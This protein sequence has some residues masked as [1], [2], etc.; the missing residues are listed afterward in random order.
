MCSETRPTSSG[1]PEVQQTAP[2][3]VSGL[4]RAF[5]V[6]PDVD[7]APQANPDVDLAPP[8]LHHALLDIDYSSLGLHHAP[9]VNP[10]NPDL[11]H[12]PPDHYAHQVNPDL[13]HPQVNPDLDHAPPRL[14]HASPRLDH[15]LE[16]GSELI[17]AQQRARDSAAIW[18]SWL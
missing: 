16:T 11:D 9:Q 7:R 6:N 18:G 5:Q 3:Q 8:G 10:V 4:N 1:D 17:P 15:A 13:D 14:D 12:T 2:D